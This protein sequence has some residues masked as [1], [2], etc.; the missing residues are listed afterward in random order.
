M[1]PRTSIGR[2]SGTV[3]AAIA[4]LAARPAA[5]HVVAT[6]NDNSRFVVLTALGDRV[7]IAYTVLFGDSPARAERAAMDADRDGALSETEAHAFG[8]RL[9]A[10]VAAGLTLDVDGVPRPVTWAEVDVGMGTPATA[11]GAFSVDLIAYAC[12]AQPRGAHRLRLRDRFHLA[13][14]GQLEL[15]AEDSPGVTIDRARVG[16]LDAPDNDFTFVGLGG[17][18]ADDGLELAITA[19][20]DAVVTADGVC[21]AAPAEATTGAHGSAA[22]IAAGVAAGALVGGVVVVLVR[23]KR[24]RR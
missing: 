2:A 7:R 5:A 10:D 3:A 15:K 20:S 18:P 12:F 13:H 4:L 22:Y 11:A 16:P 9:A 8:T 24:A 19:G 14:A 1:A 23:R 17:P 6:D 21:E